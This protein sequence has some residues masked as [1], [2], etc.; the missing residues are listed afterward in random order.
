MSRRPLSASTSAS[1]GSKCQYKSKDL[2]MTPKVVIYQ[3][4]GTGRDSYV[5]KS[6]GGFTK[7]LDS[8]SSFMTSES[9]LI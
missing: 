5:K 7:S 1:F 4:N 2:S 3:S 8:S 6:N 9:I